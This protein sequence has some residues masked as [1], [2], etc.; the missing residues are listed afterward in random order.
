MLN[1]A[2]LPSLLSLLGVVALA[3]FLLGS[4]L[5]TTEWMTHAPRA[6]ATTSSWGSTPEA[7]AAPT[8]L[9]GDNFVK[10]TS[11]NTS[12]WIANGPEAGASMTEMGGG[13]TPA[14]PSLTFSSANGLTMSGASADYTYVNVQSLQAF[15]PPF[16]A[17]VRGMVTAS[18]GNP[19]VMA[20]ATA[21]G[22]NGVDLLGN[23]DD[24]N[25][26]YGMGAQYSTGYDGLWEGIQALV[27]APQLDVWYSLTIAVNASGVAFL[28]IDEGP[29]LLGST[30]YYVGLGAYYLFLGQ[31]VDSP[32]ATGANSASW[33]SAYV[34]QSAGPVAPPEVIGVFANPEIV[35]VG[36]S[37]TLNVLVSGGALPLNIVYSELPPGCSTSPAIELQCAPTTAGTYPISVT[38]TDAQGRTSSGEVTLIVHSAPGFAISPLNGVAL[39]LGILAVALAV[40]SLVLGR[41]HRRP[42]TPPAGP[43]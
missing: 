25:P 32:P 4:S 33:T 16:V 10:D 28:S 38:V 39:G 20:L 23:M 22:A 13:L 19:L 26:Y 34:N 24:T 18:H 3:V 27:A 30:T 21:N 7:A 12:L 31:F 35:T 17:Q 42:G 29:T 37:T 2:R 9:F 11:L 36:E 41:R 40:T 15:F 1:Q 8:V 5:H 43:S 14:T 6:N